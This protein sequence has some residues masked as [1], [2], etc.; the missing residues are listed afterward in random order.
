MDFSIGLSSVLLLV[1][2]FLKVPVFI[3]ILGA[4]ATYFALHTEINSVILAQ[5]VL[6]GSQ[7]IP[8]LAIPFFVCAGVFMNYTGVTKRIV[9]FCE[10][11]VGNIIGGIGHVTVL[12][13]TLMGGLSGSNLADAA[14]EAKM[15]VPEM[16]KRGFSKAFGSV[17][18][19]TSA[20]ITP[21]I[22]PG[23][24]MIIYGSIANVSIGKLFVA[25]IGPGVILCITL[26]I[27][28]AL[29]SYKRGYRSTIKVDT[30]ASRV[31]K[32]FRGAFLPLC[33]PVI[34]IGGIRIGA[35]T[36]TEAGSVAI[37]YSLFL[38]FI[39]RE[40]TLKDVIRGMKETV[41]TSSAIMLIIAAASAFA[42]A[43]TKEKVPQYF[44]GLFIEHLNNPVI[45]LLCVNLFLLIIGMFIE[46]NAAMIILVPLLA[47]LAKH[48][49]IDEI[50]FAMV[51]IFNFALGAI[52]PP[53]GTL[54]F[55]TCSITKCPMGRFI[56][57]AIPFYILLLGCLLLLTFVPSFST[58]LVNLIY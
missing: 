2:L 42:W 33:L 58:A 38:G 31:W 8:L 17:L 51:V 34:I 7:S 4:A 9:D 5:R 50:H 12:V 49:G 37:V 26:M 53:M 3:S 30:S 21:L 52:S 45:F 19:A 44:T 15:L 23:I 40:M 22:P 1:F 54:M 11:V 35:F 29:V 24:A 56:K 47:P 13:A 43:L 16:E 28:V 25:G 32:T 57:E 46:G 20:I 39:Y 48:F 14:M 10:A 18:V 6:A 55:V 27:L 36:P 41:L